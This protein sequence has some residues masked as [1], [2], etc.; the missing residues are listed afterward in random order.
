MADKTGQ[1]ARLRPTVEIWP[2]STWATVFFMVSDFPHGHFMQRKHVALC[3]HSARMNRVMGCQGLC[4]PGYLTL[5]ACLAVVDPRTGSRV[6]ANQKNLL[7]NPSQWQCQMG[8]A[9]CNVA[10]G[11]GDLPAVHST[12]SV[13]H[14]IIVRVRTGYLSTTSLYFPLPY[15][16][17][18]IKIGSHLRS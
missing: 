6:D 17:S 1:R 8:P 15:A 3:H 16:M 14:V 4:R 12:W 18:F 7:V 2:R 10:P 5:A 9:R 13:H 11:N